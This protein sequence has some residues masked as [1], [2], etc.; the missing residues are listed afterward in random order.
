MQASPHSA[1]ATARAPR[2]DAARLGVHAVLLAYT[3]L[4]WML[5][6]LLAYLASLK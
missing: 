1:I 6:V 2:L 4:G 3:L 5:M